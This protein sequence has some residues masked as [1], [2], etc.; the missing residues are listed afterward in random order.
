[1]TGSTVAYARSVAQL[2][3][4]LQTIK[5]TVL[6]S[7]PRIYERVYAAIHAKLEAG[8]PLKRK[9]FNFAVEV[10]WARFLHQQSRGPWKVSFLFWPVLSHLVARKILVKMGGRLRAA[11]SGGAALSAEI[12]RMF[13]GL[14]CRGA[15]LRPDRNQPVISA[16]RWRTTF[17]I[18]RAAYSRFAGAHRRSRMPR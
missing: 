3:E 13:V 7:V 5:P 8:P 14:V 9:L 17:R 15:G 10:G 6:V 2:G 1:M 4:D 16:S 18:A 12:S 11:I